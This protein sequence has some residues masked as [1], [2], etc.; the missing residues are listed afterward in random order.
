[1]NGNERQRS[2]SNPQPVLGDPSPPPSSAVLC[3]SLPGDGARILGLAAPRLAVAS[4]RDPSIKLGDPFADP[5]PTLRPS[6]RRSDDRTTETGRTRLF[7]QLNAEILHE[8]AMRAAEPAC[9]AP[10]RSANDS[11]RLQRRADRR[12]NQV[13]ASHRPCPTRLTSTRPD[14]RCLG[15][16]VFPWPFLEPLGSYV[17]VHSAS[18]VVEHV[19]VLR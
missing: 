2:A 3:G 5:S 6:S 15:C 9:G 19:R 14:K 12:R 10:C 4:R 13:L 8:T 16:R 7:T 11:R 1:M 18:A 17:F